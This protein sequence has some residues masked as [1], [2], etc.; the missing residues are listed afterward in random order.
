ME[1]GNDAPGSDHG[2]CRP[3]LNE[4]IRVDVSLA[5]LNRISAIA[6]RAGAAAMRYYGRL[7]AISIKENTSP[8]TAADRAAH[9]VIVR[10]LH[11]WDRT[12][13]IIS[14]E[15][16]IPSYDVRCSWSRLWL[17]DPLD[18]TKEFIAGNGEF[19]VNIALIEDGAPVLGVVFAPA[20]PTVY[21]AGRGLGAWKGRD[22]AQATRLFGPQRKTVLRIVESRSH[23]S[24]E[25]E[26]FVTALGS[27]ERIQLGS[28]LKFCRIAEGE[29]DLYPRFG[30]T[31]EWD[32]AAGD[33]IYRNS[34][35]DDRQ[36]PS[37]LRYNQPSLTI[38]E[39]LIGE[40][41]QHT[42]VVDGR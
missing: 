5:S 27:V 10:A 1:R 31:M 9:D 16:T 39:F 19:T 22:G 29:A 24:P 38:P 20:L 14:E 13:P 30:P 28:S 4:H 25:L 18:G 35:A 36:R 8:V 3:V 41:V 12:I 42:T 40:I 32:V 7:T 15:S 33:C 34:R 21:C 2:W 37:S 26:G 11:D 17:V 6:Q 23:P